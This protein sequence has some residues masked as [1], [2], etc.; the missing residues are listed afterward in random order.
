MDGHKLSISQAMVHCVV[1]WEL[2]VGV[3]GEIYLCLAIANCG[4]FQRPLVRNEHGDPNFFKITN[5][6]PIVFNF[7]EFENILA[8]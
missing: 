2:Y 6:K 4:I 5:K 8:I 3:S 1:K 7:A